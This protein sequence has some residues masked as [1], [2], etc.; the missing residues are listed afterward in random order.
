MKDA[1]LEPTKTSD[2]DDP[3]TIAPGITDEAHAQAQAEHKAVPLQPG[4]DPEWATVVSWSAHTTEFDPAAGKKRLDMRP[5]NATL[6]SFMDTFEDCLVRYAKH[7]CTWATQKAA[8]AY[9][10]QNYYPGTLITDMGF[11][12]NHEI[13]YARELQSN[14]WS[15]KSMTLFI[16]TSSYLDSHIFYDTSEPIP[17]G[18]NV[19]VETSNETPYHAVVKSSSEA[20]CNVVRTG[21]ENCTIIAVPRELCRHRVERSVANVFATGD[22]LHDS[23]ATQHY[24]LLQMDW[25]LEQKRLGIIDETFKSHHIH[26][27]NAG[28]HFKNT[29]SARFLTLYRIKYS[30][31]T[32]TWSFGCPGHGKGP[33]D[34]LGGTLKNWLGRQAQEFDQQKEPHRTPEDCAKALTCHFGSETWKVSHRNHTISQIVTHYV[35]PDEIKRDGAHYAVGTNGKVSLDLCRKCE[36]ASFK[37]ARSTYDVWALANE[38]VGCRRY[39]CWC[40]GCTNTPRLKADSKDETSIVKGC[41][42]GSARLE[43]L[44]LVRTDAAGNR[45]TRE[46]NVCPR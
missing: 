32:A 12:E 16:S 27:D 10:K 9:L 25:F 39:S 38:K 34:G 33:W 7:R 5:Q 31:G 22:R 11:A 17:D 44:E 28:Q 37:G 24:M 45:K 14:Y 19:T 4:T 23:S 40:Y 35:G 15:H 6:A 42:A 2:L 8:A 29:Y 13:L 46:S 41:M 36:I 1:D 3:H 43:Y 21:D 18:A 26:S 30:L 20:T